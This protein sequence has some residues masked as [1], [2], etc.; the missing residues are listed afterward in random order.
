MRSQL[1]R[2]RSVQERHPASFLAHSG[3]I[4]RLGRRIDVGGGVEESLAQVYRRAVLRAV[5]LFEQHLDGDA[6]LVATET[7]DSDE[8]SRRVVAPLRRRLR[9]TSAVL[10]AEGEG[11]EQVFDLPGVDDLLDLLLERLDDVQAPIERIAVYLALA[12]VDA[13]RHRN[14]EVLRTLHAAIKTVCEVGGED[15]IIRA[16]DLIAEQLRTAPS[17]HKRMLYRCLEKLGEGIARRRSVPL[18]EHLVDRVI[19]TGFEGPDLGGVSEEWEVDVNPHHLPCLRAWLA[20]IEQDPIGYERLLSALVVNLHFKGVFVADTDLFQRDISALLNS[21]VADAFNLIMQLVRLFPVFY[22]EVG[23]EGELRDTSTRIDQLWHRRD[24]VVH[25]LRKQCHAESNNRLIDFTRAVWTW[26]RTEDPEVLRRHVPDS[27]LPQLATDQPWFRDVHQLVLR[28]SQEC[29]VTE[30]DL[31]AVPLDRL[32]QLLEELAP[33]AELERERQRVWLL[34]RIHRL[35]KAKYAFTPE[36]V[37]PLVEQSSLVSTPARRALTEACSGSD[38]L[39]VV[40]AGNHVLKELKEVVVDPEVTEAFENIFLKRHIAAGI[41]SMYG[42]YR[43]PKFDAMGLM[44]RVIQLLKPQLE[45]CIDG[46]ACRYMTRESIEGALEIMEQMIAGLRVAGLRVHHLSTKLDILRSGI[47]FGHL[48]ASQYLNIFDFMSDALAGAIETNY[49]A[50]HGASL[51][52]VARQQAEADGVPEED[53]EEAAD[54]MSEEFLRSMIASTYAIQELDLFLRRIRQSLR[55]LTE[56]LSRDV[57]DTVLAYRPERLVVHLDTEHREHEDQVMLGFKGLAL[58]RLAALGLKV[59]P[60]FV[61]STELF[62][63]RHAITYEDLAADTRERVLRAVARLEEVSGRRLGDPERP[64]LLSVRSGSAFSMPGMMDTILDVGLDEDL[65]EHMARESDRAWGVWDSWRRYLQNV[66]MSCGMDRNLFDDAMDRFKER[67]GVAKKLELSAEQ[68]RELALEYRRIATEHGVAYLADPL[69]QL[70]QAVYLVLASWDSEPAHLYRERL[71]LSDDWGTGVVVQQMVFGNMAPDAGSG[72]VFT[73]DPGLSGTGIALFG[74]YSRGS[75][76]EDVVAG[77]VRPYPIS[78]RQRQRYSPHLGRS[79]ETEFPAIFERLRGVASKL[80]LEEGFEHQEME[81]TFESPD[82]D[83]LYLLQIRPMRHLQQPQA[84]V[85]ASPAEAQRFL[86]ATGIGVSG[87]AMVGV[88]ALEKADIRAFRRDHPAMRIILLRPDTVPDDIDLILA[89]D[90]L[91]TSRGGFTS[92]AAVTAKR[93]G[94]CCVVNCGDLEVSEA[95]RRVRL[96]GRVLRP[97]DVLTIDGGNGRVYFGE[98]EITA[99]PKVPRL[100]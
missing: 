24:P 65:A 99:A 3:L 47:R 19:G 33:A 1:Q 72:V 46:F 74:D 70:M 14:M 96:G 53:L 79:L 56:A 34:A 17:R 29:G 61:L 2:L 54:R 6:W 91:L 95:D 9:Q 23:S 83:D 59:P 67:Y 71:Q 82:A 12:R 66:A 41:P 100:D 32:E 57:C 84:A 81:F 69:D 52:R 75:Q 15:D 58:K 80:L 48:S 22:N 77:L 55:G 4:R 51:T 89:T 42:T 60:G 8:V 18:S 13:L 27:L 94:R 28:L 88:V 86:L 62:D 16:V 25:F 20:I 90:G 31:D 98:Q 50:L 38:P 63:I 5:Q 97:G 37:L 44:L 10:E 73:R 35:L 36:A 93:L 68:M 64:L 30:A 7:A 85:L 76:G 49:I 92:H 21:H 39:A 78:E 43:E 87:G 26:W 11:E 45:A 40:R